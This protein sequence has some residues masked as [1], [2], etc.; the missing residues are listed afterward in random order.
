MK[1]SYPYISLVRFCRLLGVTRQA[2]YQYFWQAQEWSTEVE[3]VVDHV[4][5]LRKEHP[6]IGGRKLYYLLQP[7]LQEH[8]IKLGRDALFD[9][10]A[11][12][13]L[14]VRKKRRKVS[15]TISH[16]WLKKYPNLIKEWNPALPNQLWV[17]DITYLRIPDGF[18]YISLVTDAYSHKILGYHIANS[19]E[20][21][22]TTAAL[23]M[24]L[25]QYK[26]SG[27]LIHHSD[28][29]IQYCSADYVQL[30]QQHNIQISMT[31]T[32]DPLDNAIAERINGIIKNEYLKYHFI[33]DQTS[34]LKILE[35]T[36]MKYN[37][38]R[39]HQSIQ[40]LTPQHVHEHQLQVNR[41][42]GKNH[43]F[44]TTVN[45]LQD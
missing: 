15:T 41:K 39:P 18:L 32:G 1:D 31:E 14:L 26:P 2:F 44:A 9:I 20:A 13:K 22:H 17:A 36:V 5:Q 25:S 40:M 16:H 23:K 4:K 10:L 6:V 35:T 7:F 19:L 12:H 3:L 34:A 38:K 33:N 29:G 30:L 27:Q 24:A 42:W 21:V 43:N 45:T 8:Q 11:N 37:Q 28:R